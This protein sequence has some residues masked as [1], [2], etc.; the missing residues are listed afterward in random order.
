MG[1]IGSR[2][3]ARQVAL[4]A[5]Y[6]LDCTGHSVPEVLTQRLQQEA[7]PDDMR[8]FVYQ[9]VNGVLLHRQQLDD[10]IQEYA[11]EWPVDQM[12]IIDRNILRMS[13]YE[14]AISKSAPLR[15]VINEA[16]ELA[17]DYGAE[18]APRFVNGVLGS[19]AAKEDVIAQLFSSQDIEADV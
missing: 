17:K 6:E 10:L 8:P 19:L 15:V 7:L 11:P 2:H 16:V 1:I 5:L 3:Q 13:I 4:Q 12:A 14:I 18:T 9:L